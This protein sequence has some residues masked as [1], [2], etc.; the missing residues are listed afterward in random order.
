M[1]Q[2]LLLVLGLISEKD[3]WEVAYEKKIAEI[4][5]RLRS[6]QFETV[7]QVIVQGVFENKCKEF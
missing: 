2:R 1:M 6:S 5:K 3:L 4:K 7:K